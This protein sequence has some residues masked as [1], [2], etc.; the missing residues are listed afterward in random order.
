MSYARLRCWQWI[1]KWSSL[2]SMLFLLM[3]CITGLPLIF[4]HEIDALT[5]AVEPSAHADGQRERVEHMVH[6]ALERHAD[7]VPQFLVA[8][9][10]DPRIWFVRLGTTAA[11]ADMSAFEAYDAIT[12]DFLYAH[13]LEGGFMNVMTR[14]HVDL[15]AGLPGT[16]FLGG[17]GLAGLLGIV[18]GIVLYAPYARGTA[19]GTVRVRRG[20]RL[21]WVDLHNVTGM[22]T[23]MWLFVVAA[24]GVVNTL[25]TPIFE[26][27][28]TTELADMLAPHRHTELHSTPAVDR[29]LASLAQAYPDRT[30]SF[31]A[32]P[33]NEFAGPAHF[34][35]F[36]RGNSALGVRLLTPVLIDAA[37]GEVVDQRALP[38]LVSAL[39][40]AQPLHFGDYGGLP[41]KLAWG[42]LDLVSIVVLMTGIVLWVGR[43][44][45]IRLARRGK[46]A[47]R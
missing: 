31:M 13:P 9:A 10:D 38:W 11:S 44:D 34:V 36:L 30:L 17:M 20:W 25:A 23:A 18:S 19:F 42:F 2:V 33:G 16:L 26:Q 27:W 1:H 37:S 4:A 46:L 29:A 43:L 35:A 5:I 41:L 8:D 15:F 40:L 6:R 14:L 22:V 21:K 3:L 24:T 12:G 32:F 45:C 47:A 39:L 7:A 28:Q